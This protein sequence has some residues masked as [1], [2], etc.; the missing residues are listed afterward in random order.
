VPREW[1]FGNL[2]RQNIW[3]TVWNGILGLG[4]LIAAVVGAASANWTLV[5]FGLGMTAFFALCGWLIYPRGLPRR[6][7]DQ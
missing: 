5:A 2:R 1:R 6:G 3:L 7:S 4:F